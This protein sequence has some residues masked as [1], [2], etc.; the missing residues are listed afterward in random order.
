MPRT[1]DHERKKAESVFGAR[2]RE[3]RK[4]KGLTLMGLAGLLGMKHQALSMIE[5]G[6]TQPTWPT[7]LSIAGAL[8]VR[9]DAF[10]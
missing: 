4:R 6:Q 1:R 3:I 2:M 7:V 8:D 5:L 9:I 10:R